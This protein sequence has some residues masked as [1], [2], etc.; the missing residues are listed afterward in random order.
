MRQIGTSL[1]HIGTSRHQ[2]DTEALPARKGNLSLDEQARQSAR[3]FLWKPFL[4]PV[5]GWGF[6]FPVLKIL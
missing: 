3:D 6:P 2:K 5:L 1:S 4:T